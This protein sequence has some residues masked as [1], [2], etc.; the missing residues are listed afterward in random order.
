MAATKVTSSPRCPFCL[1]S[2]PA[3]GPWHSASPCRGECILSRELGWEGTQAPKGTEAGTKPG[4]TVP[5]L[6]SVSIAESLGKVCQPADPSAGKG[7]QRDR[8]HKDVCQASREGT[9]AVG[10]QGAQ[11]ARKRQWTANYFGPCV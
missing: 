3:W 8:G 6:A 5:Q 11:K 1:Q 10:H 4:S 9:S 2:G 7:G